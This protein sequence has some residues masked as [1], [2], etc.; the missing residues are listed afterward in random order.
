MSRPLVVMREEKKA[1]GMEEI[2]GEVRE[3]VELLDRYLDYYVPRQYGFSKHTIM[4]PVGKLLSVLESGK[5]YDKD[6]LV[7]YV[8]NVHRN[9][10]R[11]DYVPPEALRVLEEAVEKLIALRAKLPSRVWIKALREIDYAVYK[12][13][14]AKAAERAA[15]KKAGEGG[16]EE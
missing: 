1:P 7:G 9:T 12:A 15:A 14:F 4:G 13:R 5:L 16:G 10:A 2:R 8:V 6:A 11:S 3:I